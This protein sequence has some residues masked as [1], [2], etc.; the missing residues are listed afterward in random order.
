[1]MDLEQIRI[2]ALA[3]G[4]EGIGTLATGKRVFVPETA[5]GD[6]VEIEV[7]E[8]RARF[9]RGR[10]VRLLEAGPERVTPPCAHARACGGCQLQHLS[11]AGQAAAKERIFYETL[12]RLGGIARDAVPDARPIELAPAAFRYRI[13]CRLQAGPDGL[14]YFRR[15]THERVAIE[16]CLLLAPPLEALALRLG[17]RLRTTPIP[18]LAAVELCIGRDGR[19][20]VAL[21]PRPGAPSRWAQGAE[22]LLEVEGVEGVVVLPAREGRPPRIFGDPVVAWGA[23]MAP[24]ISLLLRPDVFAQAN[25]A[26]N[27][28]LVEA[29]VAALAPAPGEEVLEFYAGAGNFTFALAHRGARVTAVEVE[30][31]AIDLARRAAGPLADRIDFVAAPAHR[32]VERFVREGRRFDAVLLDPPRTGAKEIVAGLLALRPRR[33]AYVSCDP[34]TLARDL[35][36]LVDGGYHVRLAQPFDLFPQTYHLEGL[37]L[38]EAAAPGRS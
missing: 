1:M 18:H 37:V 5:P 25:A 10:V 13:R 38:L 8:R 11:V 15:R 3:H 31:V 22:R 4:G 28:R 12:A 9:D 6:W 26:A 16:S 23:P 33:I 35:R 24:G 19:G 27:E 20:A 7:F 34:A 14:G 30:G 21:A 32:A 29:A 17:D 2:D 36:G